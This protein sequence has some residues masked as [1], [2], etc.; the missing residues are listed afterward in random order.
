MVSDRGERTRGERTGSAGNG[1]RHPNWRP[2]TP[3]KDNALRVRSSERTGGA[4]HGPTHPNWRPN[5]PRKDKALSLKSKWQSREER[6]R[7]QW[8]N[9]LQSC[10]W[11]GHSPGLTGGPIDDMG[12]IFP[13][14][15]RKVWS[16]T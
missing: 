8:T 3:G 4:G 7:G 13:T 11:H 5:T 15:L 16:L 12:V 1:T 10:A 6:R 2:N 14:E 9:S